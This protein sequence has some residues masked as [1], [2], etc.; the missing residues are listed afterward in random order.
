MAPMSSEQFRKAKL[1]M[2][3]RLAR[4]IL[5]KLGEMHEK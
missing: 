5:W 1:K 2:R 4:L 3:D